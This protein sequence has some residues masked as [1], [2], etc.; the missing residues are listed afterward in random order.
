MNTMAVRQIQPDFVIQRWNQ[1]IRL[2]SPTDSRVGKSEHMTV[3]QVMRQPVNF[4]FM[5]N[6]S[7]ML[8]LNELTAHTCGYMS[9]RDAIGRSIRDVS[10]RDTAH[11]IIKNDRHIIKT[12]KFTVMTESYTRNDEVDLIAI[13]LKFPWYQDEKVVGIFGCSLIIQ[14]ADGA[15]LD[16]T[17]TFLIHSGLLAPSGLNNETLFMGKEIYLDDRERSI[18][19]L[20]LRGQTAKQIGRVLDISHRTVEHRLEKLKLRLGVANRAELIEKVLEWLR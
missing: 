7:T 11:R 13:S 20:L 4:Y 3:R 9:V 16:H 5:D 18:L 10:L 6:N 14:G 8:G 19:K 15:P 2:I 12:K 1:G 17:L